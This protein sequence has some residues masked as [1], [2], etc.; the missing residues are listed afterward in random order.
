MSEA[1]LERYI[2][3]RAYRMSREDRDDVAQEVM[4]RLVRS[5]HS[6][7]RFNMDI[8]LMPWLYTVTRHYLIDRWRHHKK[9][10][11]LTEL[12]PAKSV[13]TDYLLQNALDQ[14]MRRLTWRQRLALDLWVREGWTQAEIA[15]SLGKPET[16]ISNDIKTAKRLLQQDEV[17]SDI[18][19]KRRAV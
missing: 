16:T 5:V 7:L 14:A 9:T 6:G 10:E 4:I 13:F 8:R 1:P 18:M 19:K 3:A 15:L 12:E 17:L 2:L 11:P